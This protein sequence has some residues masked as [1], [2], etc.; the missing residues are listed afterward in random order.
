MTQ[1]MQLRDTMTQWKANYTQNVEK[2]LVHKAF[3]S[4]IFLTDSH[5]ID[6]STFEIAAFLP[7]SH[8]L[9]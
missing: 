8:N 5:R 2:Y 9:L 7:R 4:E 3:N 6:E 1:R